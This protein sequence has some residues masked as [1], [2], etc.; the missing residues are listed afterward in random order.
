MKKEQYTEAFLHKGLSKA[1]VE[2]RRQQ[3]GEN[4]LTPPKRRSLWQLY[5]EKYQDPIIQILLFAGVVSLVLAFIHGEIIETIGIFIA[6]FLATTI[7]FY[8][9]CDAAKKFAVLNAIG[10]EQPVKVLRDGEIMLIP[11][12]EIVVGD[13]VIVET[14]DEIP[15]DGDLVKSTDLQID[16]SSLTGEPL[17][18][19]HAEESLN[20]PHATYPSYR[21]M[22]ST[23]VMNGRGEMVVTAVGNATEIGKVAKSAAEDTDVETPLNIQLKR[24]GAMINKIGFTLSIAAFV[25]FLTHHIFTQIGRAHV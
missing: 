7:G 12:K 16:E 4:V 23:M 9:E 18:D 8:F 21:V 14:G 22:R 24:L 19:K 15:A 11:R 10:E 13:L 17:A 3:Y 5:L 2:Q 25:I 1:E 6:I 20:D